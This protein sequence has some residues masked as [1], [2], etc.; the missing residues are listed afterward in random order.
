V[1]LGVSAERRSDACGGLLKALIEGAWPNSSGESNAKKNRRISLLMA[2]KFNFTTLTRQLN[3]DSLD[4]RRSGRQ[5]VSLFAERFPIGRSASPKNPRDYSLIPSA[6]SQG[7]PPCAN[8]HTER[9]FKSPRVSLCAGQL[10]VS[11]LDHSAG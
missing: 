3:F 4:V 1:V 5:H 9:S 6:S 8:A 2:K 7:D 11:Q 10:D